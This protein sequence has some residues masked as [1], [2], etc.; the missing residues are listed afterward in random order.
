MS[1]ATLFSTPVIGAY[2]G[3]SHELG[4]L[5]NKPTMLDCTK[6]GEENVINIDQGQS[7]ILNNSQGKSIKY[8][9]T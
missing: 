9:Q 7:T 8:Q 5:R 4:I 6:G 1:G 2:T 3:N